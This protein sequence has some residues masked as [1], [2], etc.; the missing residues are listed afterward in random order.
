MA[1]A[2]AVAIANGALR[3]GLL[4][5]VLT[6]LPDVLDGAVAKA[7][8]TAVAR[9]APSST[10]WPTG[11]PTP[12]CSAAWPGTWRPPSPGASRCCPSP[13]W[14]P[15]AHLLR[16]GQGRVAR[17]RRPRRAHGA[18]RAPAALA[19]GL[20]FDSLLVPVLW[21]MLA[22]TLFTAVQRFAKVWRQAS[23]PQVRAAAPRRWR[24][25]RV[26]R[27]TER[28][29]RRRRDAASAA[30]AADTAAGATRRRASTGCAAVDLVTPAYR[31]RPPW[32]GGCPAPWS[33]PSPH[34]W[35]S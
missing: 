27:S 33:T 35:P 5:L 7:S 1:G 31:R 30:R 2:A 23:A 10:R 9:G 25:R 28:T 16:A 19:L 24:G 13:C 3:A 12:C 4:L 32:P 6:G 8:G 17:L 26:A 14:P 22:L 15:R 29:W 20:L 34:A 18:G 21:V 11:S